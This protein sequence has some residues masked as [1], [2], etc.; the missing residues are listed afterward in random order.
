MLPGVLVTLGFWL[1]GASL[2]SLY[3]GTVADD[4]VTYGSLDGVAL[5][6]FF[7]YPT[8]LLF[9]LGAEYNVV[10]RQVKGTASRAAG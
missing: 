1:V 4:S 7:F 2:F 8:A 10:R 6:L 9:I 5:T 3:L